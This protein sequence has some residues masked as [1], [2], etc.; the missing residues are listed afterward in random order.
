MA[1][2]ANVSTKRQTDKGEIPSYNKLLK[3]TDYQLMYREGLRYYN[4]R[5]KG[6][7]TTS[8]HNLSRAQTLL[9][10]AYQSQR[11]A[12]TPQQDSLMYYLGASFY[13]AG[14]FDISGS[15]FDR[16]RRDFPMSIFIEDAEYMYAM[17]YYFS[18]PDP[19]HDQGP[20]LRAIAAIAEYLGRYPQTVKRK[21]CEERTQELYRKLYTKSYNNARLYYTIRQYKAA[22]RALNNAID[23]YPLSPYREE[24]M[25]LATRSAWLFARNSVASQMTDRYLSMMDN[26]LNLISEY[27]ETEYR[28]E[29]EKMRDEAQKHIDEHTKDQNNNGE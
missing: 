9:D 15:A 8:R 13:K 11:F 20:T 18:S 4:T 14:D 17:G 2:R 19:E 24:L 26:Y 23:E 10:K 25:Y 16:F 5:K 1:R 12:G 28:G 7:E 22:V 3:S 29:V 21:E 27:P 6:K